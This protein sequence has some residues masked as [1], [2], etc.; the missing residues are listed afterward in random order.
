MLKSVDLKERQKQEILPLKC[1]KIM[2]DQIKRFFIKSMPNWLTPKLLE[3]PDTDKIDQFCA[4][5]S[6]QIAI[7]EICNREE[8]FD[9]GFNEITESSTDKLLKAMFVL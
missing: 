5:A 2:N 4:L 7:T 1:R 6:Q 3:R 8:Y 9:N